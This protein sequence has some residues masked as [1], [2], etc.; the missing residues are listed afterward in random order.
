MIGDLAMAEFLWEDGR[1]FNSFT[2]EAGASD[3]A[4]R[5]VVL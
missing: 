2:A 1:K 3:N 4:L 5:I